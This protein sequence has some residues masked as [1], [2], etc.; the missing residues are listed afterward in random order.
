LGGKLGFI[1]VLYTWDQKLNDHFH[2]NFFIA[3]GAV[4]KN[5]QQWILCKKNYLFNHETLALVFRGKFIDYLSRAVQGGQ[6]SFGNG[7]LPFKQKLTT[8]YGW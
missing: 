7:Y 1:C 2:L 6:L 8:I 4:S 5:G 3:G